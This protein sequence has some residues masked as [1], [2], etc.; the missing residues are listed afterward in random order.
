MTRDLRAPFEQYLTKERNLSPHTHAA[1]R[2]DLLDLEIFFQEKNG[3]SPLNSDEIKK[4]THRDLRIWVGHLMQLGLKPRSISR[5]VSA[6]R[7]FFDYWQRQGAVSNNPARKLNLPKVKRE[8]PAFL[9]EAET[10]TLL[11]EISFPQTFEGER[12]RCLLE[13]L[14]GCGL[15][16]SEVIGL[17]VSDIQFNPPALKVRGK[18]NKDR[19]VPFGPT[20]DVA[21]KR[22][23]NAAKEAGIQPREELLVRPSGEPLYPNLVYRVVQ[24]YLSLVTTLHTKSPHVLRH[25]YATHLLD[26]G[27]DLNS[28]KELLGHESLAAT[29]VYTHN[30]IRKLKSVHK[31]AHPRAEQ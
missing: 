30:S 2:R 14:Y 15:R 6:V 12:D 24:R 27:A 5:K 10:Q 31:Q 22:Y 16:R 28:I 4:V 13:L 23:L 17:Q 19:I 9:K 1:Y 7:S 21:L 3:F 20:L 25:T 26:R 29:Q 11:D 18:G 8:L